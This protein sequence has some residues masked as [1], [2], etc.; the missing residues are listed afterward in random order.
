MH[1]GKYNKLIKEQ[2]SIHDLDFNDDKSEYSANIFNKYVVDPYAVYDVLVNGHI[3][4]INQNDLEQLDDIS[5]LSSVKVKNR[6]ELKI[7]ANIYSTEYQKHSLNWLDVSGIIDMSQMF[8]GYDDDDD[9]VYNELY[10]EYNGDIS[11][12]DVS[13]VVNMSQMFMESEFNSNISDWDVSNVTD[14]SEMFCVGYFNQNISKWDVSNVEDMECMFYGSNFNG[15]IGNWDVSKV[16]NM[17][18]M[19]ENSHFN[20]DISGWDVSN[21]KNM[22]NMF[23]NTVFNYDI[24][25]WNVS[26]VKYYKD[27]FY[28]AQINEKYK[29]KKFRI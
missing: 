2:F 11:K 7:I 15:I 16:T 26:N 28:Y 12:W 24:S 23:A 6:H 17:S 27:I 13:N 9:N 3:M 22:G 8:K 25:N 5:Y 1:L 19:F 18:Q 14:M 20:Q 21:V 10:N 4:D 29:P